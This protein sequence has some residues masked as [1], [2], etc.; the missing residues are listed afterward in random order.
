MRS[1]AIWALL[2]GTSPALAAFEQFY[3]AGNGGN[4]TAP[5]RCGD[6][7]YE[8]KEPNM[9]SRDTLTKKWYC[10]EPGNKVGPCWTGATKCE[11]P[12]A[13]KPSAQQTGCTNLGVD[14]C[15]HEAEQCTQNAKQ[16]RVC[17]S[18]E[19]NTIRFLNATTLNE[20]FSSLS[21]ASPRATQ[22]PVEA[23]QLLAWTSTTPGASAKPT[24]RPAASSSPPAASSTP[25]ILSSTSNSSSSSKSTLSTSAIG[26]IVGGL[27]G[28]LALL[29][30][31]AFLLWRRRKSAA[32]KSNPYEAPSDPY[33][34][35]AYQPQQ[36]VHEAHSPYS[37]QPGI[38]QL[39][40]VD[41]YAQHA[42]PVEVSAL[43]APVEMDAS[44]RSQ[45]RP[46]K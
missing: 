9:C 44:Y 32:R 39:P 31:I 11:G 40:A 36:P 46:G 4:A 25:T 24:T 7:I 15:C 13:D 30:A 5:R 34:G 2:L 6:M 22:Y 3:F 20:T 12:T 21:S 17:W 33:Q 43:S 23:Q 38:S 28:G 42:G 29:G 10:C 35:Y 18:K 8:C 45:V 37:P 41:K 27:L 1:Q 14:Y 19:Q 26:G 16:F